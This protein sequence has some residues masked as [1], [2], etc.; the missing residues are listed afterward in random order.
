M[1]S[2]SVGPLRS[3]EHVVSA[4]T[5]DKVGNNSALAKE[6][7]FF[8]DTR[9]ARAP[10]IITP[11]NAEVVTQSNVTVT[12]EAR[13][14]SSVRVY[15]NDK[16]QKTVKADSQG[17]WSLEIPSLAIGSIVLEPLRL[18]GKCLLRLFL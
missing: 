2:L 13:P 7:H 12:G 3:G 8:V 5:T 15:L 14:D 9:A 1:W 16:T 6:V 4:G 11:L 18:M 17:A 10:R